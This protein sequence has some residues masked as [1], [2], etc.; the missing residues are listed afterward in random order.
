MNFD[1]GGEGVAY[2]DNVLGNS[3]GQYRPNEDVDIIAS[4][5]SQGGPYV[6]NNFETSEWLVYTVKVAASA[7]Y[8]I[9]LRVASAFP[10]S[11]FHVEVDGKDVTGRVTVPNAGSWSAFQWVGK[12]GIPLTGGIHM[13]KVVSDQEFF[14][15]HQVAV[16]ATAPV[17]SPDPSTVT[18]SC[19]F[20]NSPADCGFGEQ[21][22]VAGRA[23]LVNRTRDGTSGRIALMTPTP[24]GTTGVRLHTEPGDSNVAGSGTAER[25]DLVLS[26]T[27]TDCFEGRE[28][29]W[30]HS[31][32]F[33]TDYV[34]P[35]MSTAATWNWGVVFD[36]HNSSPGAGQA[37][38]QVM[39]MPA[40]AISPDRPTGLMFQLAYGNQASPTL[41]TANVG[42][43]V[44]NSW[45]DFVYHVKWSSGSDG[46]F[47][48]WV[49]GV[50]KMAY[51]GPTIYAGQGCYLKLADYHSAFGLPSSVIHDRI[52]RG[53]T[54]AAVSLTPLQ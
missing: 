21:A 20:Q 19:T 52:V 47:D 37:N 50:K 24:V 11:A 38:F 43:V 27:A 23:S 26:Q 6:V 53:T 33:P 46:F 42:P 39:A 49:N 51:V 18:F 36:F 22:L 54:S 16:T 45:Y 3:G 28:H 31:I 48:A 17:A 7:Q 5:D 13:L 2:H 44:R 4:T 1:R 40:T 41:V 8:D 10:S 14:D 32:L 30:G 35:P 15:L 34:D 25:D 12:N 29:W 9:Q